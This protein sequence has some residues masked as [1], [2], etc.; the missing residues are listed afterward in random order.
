[1][2]SR[3]RRR[4]A[5]S[6]DISIFFREK[7]WPTGRRRRASYYCWMTV[8]VGFVDVDSPLLG[9]GVFYRGVAE[10]GVHLLVLNKVLSQRLQSPGYVF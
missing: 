4:C 9:G 3:L 1:M 6:E 5:E 2:L 8:R 7:D 10:D